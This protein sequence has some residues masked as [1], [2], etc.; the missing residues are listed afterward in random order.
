MK[1]IMLLLS[2]GCWLTAA[3]QELAPRDQMPDILLPRTLNGNAASI[4]SLKGK[5]VLIDFWATWCSPCISAMKELEEYKKVLG[6]KLEVIAVSDESEERLRKFVKA[7]PTTLNIA[8]DTAGNLRKLFPHRIIPHT[9]LIGPEG[10]VYAITS[11]S[12]INL[13][14]LKTALKAVNINLPYKKDQTGFDMET[15]FITDST[16][17][18]YF[19]LLPSAEGAGSMS[20]QF[21]EGTF[22]DRRLSAVNMPVEGLFRLAYDKNYYAT[23]NE[24]DTVQRKYE[25]QEKFGL[26]A[27]IETPDKEKLR[28]YIQEELKKH[29]I[30]VEVVMEKRK[31][32]VLVLKANKDA[33]TLLK[34]S[35]QK[36]QGY[37]AGGSHFK[38]NGVTLDALADYIEAF[39]LYPGKVLNET[40]VEGRFDIAFEFQPEK[41]DDFKE[42]MAALGLYWEKAEREV[43]MMVLKKK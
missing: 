37:D 1:K 42:K 22:K 27:W 35:T 39:G 32:K 34:P 11:P 9:V 24:Y 26:D 17:P 31:Q 18:R 23:I 3:A 38:G 13:A 28:A 6:N 43:E 41:K 19:A 25:D 4:S 10:K 7:R 36:A 8:S 2:I 20:R 12:D 30:D 21:R 14:I 5:L 15:Y 33:L 29:F 16:K 40:G